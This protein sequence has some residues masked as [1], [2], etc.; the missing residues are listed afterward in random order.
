[1]FPCHLEGFCGV[2]EL[3]PIALTS[4]LLKLQKSYVV[5]WLKED[6]HGKITEAQYGGRSGSSAV[7]SLIYLLH[8]WHVSLDI[9][10]SVIRIMFLDFRKA[11]DLIDHSIVLE[12]CCKIGIRPSLVT[13]LASY[14][15]GRTQVTKY[16]SE[17]SDK[18][19]VHGGVPQGSK[20]GPV[21]FTVHFINDL[22][23]VLK[24]PEITYSDDMTKCDNDDDDVTI[25]MDDTTVSEIID[26][27][28]HIAGEA[29]GNAEKNIRK[30]TNHQKMELNLKKCI[31]M[32]ID[33]RR[34]KTAIPLTNTENNT[35]ERVTSYKLLGLWIDNNMK[36]NSNT[37]KIVKKAAK[38]LFLLKVLKSYGASTSDMKNFYIAVIRP[39]LE[40]GVP[41]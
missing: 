12:N 4:V 33:L 41:V 30:F 37:E 2:D 31:E 14:L 17:I 19:I 35:I 8:K 10:G 16:G 22:P 15:S 1:M 23:L 20:I 24:Q 29:I 36:W 38:R 7:L 34:N 25:F 6:I 5:S 11:Y 21:V 18:R 13:W 27:K 28:N 9:P 26:I 40:Y 39:T 32:L 3:R